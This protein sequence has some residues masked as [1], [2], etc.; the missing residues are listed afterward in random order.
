MDN[1]QSALFDLAEPE[2]TP[3]YEA[4]DFPF[5]HG[6]QYLAEHGFI[7]DDWV[8]VLRPLDLKLR[9]IAIDLAARSSSGEHLLPAPNVM[10][11]ALQI[12]LAKVKVVAIG[13]DPYP[14]VGHAI[15]LAF[16]AEASVRPLPRSLA[17]IYKELESD[18]GIERAAHADLSS[19]H[20]QGVLLLNQALS[21]SAGNAG[22]HLKIGWTEVIEAV[23]AA[24]NERATPP[25]ALLWGKHAQKMAPLMDRMPQLASAHPSPLSASRGFFGSKPFSKINRL[26]T[27]SGEQPI[28]WKIPEV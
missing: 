12:P 6:A 22:A 2:N 24:L 7:A 3:L 4:Q 16:A 26:L 23:V 20:T 8:P 18:C 9:A 17:N 27:E 5:Y 15:G 13:Q 10:L 1:S 21:V 11:R 14:T 19:W 25:V 28:D